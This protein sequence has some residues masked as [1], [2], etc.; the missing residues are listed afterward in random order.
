MSEL[1]PYSKHEFPVDGDNDSWSNIFAC[2]PDGSRVLDVGC[3]TG[4]FG[5]ALE[6][7]K[8]CKVVGIDL[9]EQDI[10][11]AQGRI[12][13]A[14]VLDA[15]EPGALDTLGKFDVI[16]F[17][18]VLEHLVD[19]SATLIAITSSLN[20][21]GVV[22]YSI[23]NMAHLSVRM[24]LLEGRFGYTEE[25]I[26]DKTHIHFHDRE[27]VEILF[28]SSGYE[29]T[30]EKSVSIRYPES[31]INEH[32]AANGLIAESA[33]FEML[34]RSE[35]DVFQFVGRAIPRPAGI[36]TEGR[37][38]TRAFPPEEIRDHAT[39]LETQIREVCEANELLVIES[40]AHRS[41]AASFEQQAGPSSAFSYGASGAE[42]PAH[43]VGGLTSSG[44][45]WT[46][47]NTQQLD[48][49]VVSPIA[50]PTALAAAR[51]EDILGRVRLLCA[52]LVSLGVGRPRLRDRR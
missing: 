8:G 21:G 50:D 35:A 20:E 48:G 5:A 47:R 18:D 32:L 26:L 29:I 17:A 45:E 19:A 40:E 4:S 39:R 43:H 14:E 34:D 16:V 28:E 44:D 49:S 31:W 23:P 51:P 27:S 24:D 10:A 38:R 6:A 13:R 2:V 30:H 11:V 22:L 52:D 9:S 36:P 25:G 41:R 33:F 15:T 42:A 7:R 1:S 46:E 37:L 12:S 3:S